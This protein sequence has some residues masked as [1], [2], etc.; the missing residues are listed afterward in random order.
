MRMT[1]WR[2][3]SGACACLILQR[4]SYIVQCWDALGVLRV[5]AAGEAMARLEFQGEQA[6]IE[7][8]VC[9]H[10][11]VGCAAPGAEPLEA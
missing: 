9:G 7:S 6:G 11:I 3:P 8:T 1:L 4:G 2:A 10:R 5:G